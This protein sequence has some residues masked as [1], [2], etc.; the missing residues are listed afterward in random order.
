MDTEPSAAVVM[1]HSR[2]RHIREPTFAPEPVTGTSQYDGCFI[3]LTRHES[4][5]IDHNNY[6]ASTFLALF[7]SFS[8]Q[9]GTRDKNCSAFSYCILRTSLV[10]LHKCNPLFL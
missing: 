10:Q 2:M 7:L 9:R 5:K 6:T 3:R 4:S 1:S 8:L